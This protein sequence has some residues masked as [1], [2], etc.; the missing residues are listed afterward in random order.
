M[1]NS[2]TQLGQHILRQVAR[3]LRHEID[4]DALGADQAHNLLDLVD[5]RLG[6][7]VKQEVSLIEEEDQFRF[8]R[9]AD[10]RQLLEKLGQQPE[11]EG[12]IKTR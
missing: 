1:L 12:G 5:Q 4:A 6:R 8:I 2:H 7:P 11:Q 9:I 10:L 3:V